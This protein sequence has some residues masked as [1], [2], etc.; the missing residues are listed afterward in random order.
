[1]KTRMILLLA[2]LVPLFTSCVEKEKHINVSPGQLHGEWIQ[3]GTQKYWT[4]NSDG[5]GN[6]VDK[7]EFDDGD[8]NNGDFEWSVRQDELRHVFHGR[9]GN[10]SIPKNYTV[11]SITSTS[12]KWKDEY[13][14]TMT[15][16]KVNTL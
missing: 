3:T 4:Y 5:T 9:Q 6:K 12:M 16:S 10:Q 14:R 13:D 7:S 2:A 15:F 11:T 8:E 1:M